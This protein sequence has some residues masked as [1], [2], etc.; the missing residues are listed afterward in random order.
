MVIKSSKLLILVELTFFNNI[1]NF[2][3]FSSHLNV[4]FYFFWT[5]SIETKHKF[6]NFNKFYITELTL[7]HWI[8]RYYLIDGFCNHKLIPDWCSGFWV[9]AKR[10]G[11]LRITYSQ[12]YY[13]EIEQSENTSRKFRMWEKVWNILYMVPSPHFTLY[14]FLTLWSESEVVHYYGV[15]PL[16][17]THS[18]TH[19][20]ISIFIP[21]LTSSRC[22][23]RKKWDSHFFKGSKQETDYASEMLPK[24]Q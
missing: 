10:R 19:L 3:N 14:F 22:C 5:K 13:T 12:F 7:Y 20:P 24:Q 21:H 6:H 1:F 16:S 9:G 17:Y 2:L 15:H 23:F 11:M 4:L 8:L 18:L